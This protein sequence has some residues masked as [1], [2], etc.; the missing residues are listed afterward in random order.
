MRRI[1]RC[2]HNR[3]RRDAFLGQ[4]LMHVSGRQ[5]P[6][7]RMMMLGVVPGEEPVAVRAGILDRAKSLRK[8]RLVLQ[9]LDCASEKGLSF[10]TCG[11]EWVFVTPR[12]A[13]KNATGFEVIAEPRSA[14]I[15]N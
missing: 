6:E 3:P 14:W 11:R 13:S 2:E 10:E 8:H 5:E 7:A 4:T 9:R 15:V 12:S 1:G